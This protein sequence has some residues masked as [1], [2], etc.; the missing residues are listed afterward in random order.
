MIQ[1]LTSSLAVD[2]SRRFLCSY[3]NATDCMQIIRIDNIPNLHWER[4]VF[5]RERLMFE[6]IPE[7]KLE[8]KIAEIS[9]KIV[10]C[11]QLRVTE[12]KVK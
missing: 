8:I 2:S 5:P 1:T 9:T 11:Q 4:V 3:V 6:A 7:A 10:P 12:K